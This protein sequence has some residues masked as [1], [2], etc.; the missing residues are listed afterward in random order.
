VGIWHG[1]HLETAW[2][3]T[4]LSACIPDVNPIPDVVPP[5]TE[6]ED[7]PDSNLESRLISRYAHPFRVDMIPEAPR[8]GPLILNVVDIVII[9]VPLDPV[10]PPERVDNVLSFGRR[11]EDLSFSIIHLFDGTALQ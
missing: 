1:A 2:E 8:F 11:Q 3:Y 4:S 7:D 9:V 6:E 5:L 10:A